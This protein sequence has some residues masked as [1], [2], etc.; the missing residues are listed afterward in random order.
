M[1]GNLDKGRN[2]SEKISF[3]KNVKKKILKGRE[4]LLNSFKGNLFP[5]MSQI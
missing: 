5:I 3:L 4:D 2:S 1:F